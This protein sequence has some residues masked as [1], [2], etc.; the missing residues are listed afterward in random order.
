MTAELS[1]L[2]V[3]RDGALGERAARSDDGRL[4]GVVIALALGWSVIFILVGVGYGL[5]LYADGSIFSYSVAIGAGWA[6]HFHNIAGRL[7][8]FFLSHLPAETYVALTGDARGGIMLYGA[9]FFGAP[10]AGLLATFAADRSEGRVLFGCACLSTAVLCPM[11]FGFPTEMWVAHSVFWPALALCHYARGG[12]V[13]L[14]LVFV[15]LLA[16]ALTHEGALVFAVAILVTVAFRGPRDPAFVRTGGALVAVVA[17]WAA[18]KVELPP[19]AYYA[20][21]IPAAA[22]NFIDVRNLLALPFVELLLAALAGYGIAFAVLRR[23]APAQ[24]PLCAAMLV[25][26]ALAAYWRWFDHALHTQ[27]RYFVRTAI[28]FATPALGALAALTALRAE[29]RLWVPVP[30]VERLAAMLTDGAAALTRGAP[31]RAAAGALAIVML[32]HVVETAKF[33][34]AWSRYEAAVRMLAIGTASDPALGDPRF[35][36]SQR[37]GADLNRMSWT[38]TTHFLSVLLAPGFAPQRLVVDPS[39][40]YFWLT[41][42]L[43]TASEKSAGAIPVESRRLIRVHACLHR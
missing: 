13:G 19:D 41:C 3:M 27:E 4:R 39:A 30:M 16:L 23:L 35:V 6:Y 14:A 36:S 15:A 42:E 20:R 17:I 18:V 7:F 43:A 10:L 22:Y 8:V 32:V 5:Q 34:A 11:V 25:A 28:L 38:T 9:L 2:P 33:V 26:L 1:S 31:A 24:T 29:G 40:A 21:I 12:V 37:I